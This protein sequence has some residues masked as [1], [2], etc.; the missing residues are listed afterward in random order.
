VRPVVTSARV[1]VLYNAL[2]T[3][4]IAEVLLTAAAAYTILCAAFDPTFF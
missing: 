3:P 4:E 2:R 1:R